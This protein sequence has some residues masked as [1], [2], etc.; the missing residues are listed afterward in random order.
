MPSHTGSKRLQL[1]KRT[2]KPAMGLDHV[3]EK[4]HNLQ[5]DAITHSCSNCNYVLIKHDIIADKLQVH[6]KQLMYS[7]YSY[8][9]IS[10]A[11]P[12]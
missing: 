1:V 8:T 7:D 9:N 6:S 2:D 5:Y 10:K 12:M 4:R 11:I 3:F